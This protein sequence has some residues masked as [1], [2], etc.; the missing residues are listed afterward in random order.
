MEVVFALSLF[1]VSAGVVL[2]GLYVSVRTVNHMELESLAADL[3]VTVLSRVQMA[4]E[5]ESVGPEGFEGDDEYLADWTWLAEVS[6]TQLPADELEETPQL[7]QVEITIENSAEGFSYSVVYLLR[8]PAM[9]EEGR[10]EPA[11]TNAGG[12]R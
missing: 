3:S 1:A 2:G 5:L 9:D 11:L 4:D 10:S 12:G 7:K 6:D 8:D